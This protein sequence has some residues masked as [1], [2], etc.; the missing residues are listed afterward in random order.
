MS[1]RY[2]ITN[3][4]LFDQNYTVFAVCDEG[5]HLLEVTCKSADAQGDTE[6]LGNMYIGKVK[7]IVANLNAAFIDLGNGRTCYY[8]MEEYVHPIF[9]K[10]IGNK[11]L[12]IGDELVV[13]VVKDAVKTKFPVV[14]T[15]LNFTGKYMVLTTE[16]NRIGVS[17]KL[18]KEQRKAWKEKLADIKGEDYGV[19]VRTNAQ[20]VQESVLWEEYERLQQEYVNLK[21]TSVHKT[22]FSLLR[23]QSAFYLKELMDATLTEADE[24]ITD[25][26][27]VYDDLTSE[28]ASGL[29]LI[30]GQIRFYT[31]EY[32]L[33]KLYALETGIGEALREKVWLKSGA[34]LI[35][36]PT[37]ALTVIDVNSG[38]NVARKNPQENFLKINKEAALEIAHQL[39][40]RN[41]SG[42]CIVDFINL[43]SKEAMEELMHTFRMALKADPVQVN[44]VDITKLGLVELTRKKVKRS[45]QEQL[46]QN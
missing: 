32:S 35:I 5:H 18:S 2:I 27:A 19:I 12:C 6:L 20:T 30:D 21:K 36:S 25:L 41:I 3:V 1:K 14:T 40:L 28:R 45:L 42:I 43:D 23:G 37:E 34:Y 17:S 11:P 4:S 16:N 24:I 15:N 33:T 44:L 46:S 31:D 29:H 26:K 7:D 13:Q 38:K 9:T 8:S 10:K 39:R 22:A